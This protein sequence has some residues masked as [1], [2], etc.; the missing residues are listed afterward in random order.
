MVPLV[1]GAA[2]YA[3]FGGE[4]SLLE[5]RRLE[6]EKKAEAARLQ[7]T[8]SEVGQLRSRADSLEMDS[9]TLER[10]ARERYGMIKPGER[11]YRFVDSAGKNPIPRDTLKND[12]IKR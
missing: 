4:Y 11:L 2:Y 7:E 9:A 1:A 6:K 10:I 5:M 3:L 12:S 8:R